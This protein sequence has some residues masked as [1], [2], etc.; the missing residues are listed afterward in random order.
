M[1]SRFQPGNLI[2]QKNEYY[3]TNEI[4]HIDR[5]T[6]IDN[7]I[8]VCQLTL[9]WQYATEPHHQYDEN[10]IFYPE[11]LLITW[12]ILE[13]RD[14]KYTNGKWKEFLIKNNLWKKAIT[15]NNITEEQEETP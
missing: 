15:K 12:D 13:E 4:Y 8:D 14:K 5:I 6:P 1:S 9:M 2:V 10:S 11:D 3:N 7:E